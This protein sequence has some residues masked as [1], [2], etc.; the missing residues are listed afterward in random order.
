MQ[1]R[2]R[3]ES[4]IRPSR[5]SARQRAQSYSNRAQAFKQSS[6]HVGFGNRKHRPPVAP[7]LLRLPCRCG[8]R[9][10]ERRPRGPNDPRPMT[11]SST[12]E[13]PRVRG[14]DRELIL[15]LNECTPRLRSGVFLGSRYEPWTIPSPKDTGD[16]YGE[17]IA[18][19]NQEQMVSLRRSWCRRR[20]LAGTG[21]QRGYEPS[22]QGI[23]LI[24]AQDLEGTQTNCYSAVHLLPSNA[25][26][27]IC[28]G[29]VTF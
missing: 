25:L 29:G 8:R 14:A 21:Q 26:D 18:A 28:Q 5:Q 4:P 1:S 3:G 27:R 15:K 13:N 7:F 16:S 23:S 6:N 22:I 11:C 19:R 10:P 17:W 20:D 12:E 24:L 2:T 9:L